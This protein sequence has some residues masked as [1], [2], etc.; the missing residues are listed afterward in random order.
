MYKPFKAGVYR[1]YK[2]GMYQVLG[3]AGS[4]DDATEGQL[5]VVYISLYTSKGGPYMRVRSLKE[6]NEEVKWDDSM[7]RPRF[8]FQGDGTD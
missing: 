3:L 8:Q 2:G 1:H 5:M 6:W 4:S 7:L